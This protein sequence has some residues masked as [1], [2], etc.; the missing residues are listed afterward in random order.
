MSV[1]VCVCGGGGEGGVGVG[2]GLSLIISTEMS[3]EFHEIP[4]QSLVTKLFSGNLL[5][6]PPCPQENSSNLH[7]TS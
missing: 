7:S 5:C 3:I 1:F 4:L 2:G 6:F